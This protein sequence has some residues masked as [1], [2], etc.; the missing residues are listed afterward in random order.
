MISRNCGKGKAPF[1]MEGG[2]CSLLFTQRGS[3]TAWPGGI[4]F[5]NTRYGNQLELRCMVHELRGPVGFFPLTWAPSL[6]TRSSP[7]IPRKLSIMKPRPGLGV[8]A[9]ALPLFVGGVAGFLAPSIH[10][11]HQ[12]DFL[13]RQPTRFAELRPARRCGA[14][15]V[16][17]RGTHRMSGT[18]NGS[19]VWY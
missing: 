16:R 12:H 14:T 19:Q 2:S 7:P 4:S 9:S 18:G 10:P 5:R 17:C 8:V 1:S 6:R 15:A 11:K 3:R 13:Q